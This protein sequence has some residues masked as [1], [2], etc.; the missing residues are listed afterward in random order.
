MMNEEMTQEE[1]NK[2]I[3]DTVD[4]ILY[5]VEKTPAYPALEYFLSLIR[6]M[7]E[8]HVYKVD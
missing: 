5:M 3:R 8:K 1:K 6:T 7:T 4:H 2:V